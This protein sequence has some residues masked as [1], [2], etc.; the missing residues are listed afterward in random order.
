MATIQDLQNN[1]RRYQVL[2]G[3][4]SDIIVTLTNASDG[5]NKLSLDIKS[6]YQVDSNDVA[7]SRR[8]VGL[9]NQIDSILDRLSHE[10]LPAI[11]SSVADARNQI[12][13]LEEQ[14]RLR[15]EREE[16]ERE[17][18]ERQERERQENI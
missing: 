5:T 1:I 11:D 12:A 3:Q 6:N 7:V 8:A 10:V 16:R 13:Y 18:R 15:R 14:E 9:K 2:K 17:E 4:I